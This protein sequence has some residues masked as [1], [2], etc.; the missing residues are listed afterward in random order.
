[1]LTRVNVKEN[2]VGGGLCL[3][4]RKG[5]RWRRNDLLHSDI[6]QVGGSIPLGILSLSTPAKSSTMRKSSRV[7]VLGMDGDKQSDNG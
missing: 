5:E 7:V 6:V 2:S 3:G 1:M 4:W